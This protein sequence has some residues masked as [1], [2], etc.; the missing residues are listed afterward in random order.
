MG[1]KGLPLNHPGLVV[2]VRLVLHCSGCIFKPLNCNC[3]GSHN[4]P[5]STTVQCVWLATPNSTAKCLVEVSDRHKAQCSQVP[6]T[7]LFLAVHGQKY[8]HCSFACACVV[9]TFSVPMFCCFGRA[10]AGL[11]LLSADLDPT[12]AI[13][14]AFQR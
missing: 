9:P 6:K 1:L 11:P 12:G 13:H 4:Y 10:T 2:P 7:I 5:I 3:V 14:V 8:A